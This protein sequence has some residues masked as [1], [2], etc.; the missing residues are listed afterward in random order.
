[1]YSELES[2]I[3]KAWKNRDNLEKELALTRVV[4]EVLALLD[5]GKVRVAEPVG[6]E[7]IVNQW[8]K[9]AV[10]PAGNASRRSRGASISFA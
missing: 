4:Q 8:L 5:S 1:M 6:D 2:T 9:K 7:W 3:N 10:L